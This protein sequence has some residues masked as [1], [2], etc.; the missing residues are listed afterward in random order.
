VASPGS[1]A[2]QRLR[3]PGKPVHCNSHAFID[4]LLIGPPGVFVIDPKQYTGRIR[5]SLDG[6]AWHNCYPLDERL[7]TV[8][9][10]ARVVEAVLGAPVIPL[11]CVHGASAQWGG[12]HAQGVPI[13]PA[14]QLSAALGADAMLSA[15]QVTMLAGTARARL[16]PAR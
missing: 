1:A 2:R 9:A 13:V 15:E 5:Q 7:A 16:K 12:L 8:R 4:H 11:L 10:E 3:T 14:A 6:R